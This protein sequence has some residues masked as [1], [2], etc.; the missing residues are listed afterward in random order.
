MNLHRPLA[1]LI[2]LGA[3]A[4][5]ALPQEKPVVGL[6]PKAQKPVAMDGRLTGWDGAFVTPVHVGQPR[7]EA[8]G[9]RRCPGPR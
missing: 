7:R 6:V 3:A 2:V 4:S 5:P 8:S 1:L 9:G